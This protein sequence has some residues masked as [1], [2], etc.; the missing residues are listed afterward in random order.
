MLVMKYIFPLGQWLIA[1][2][3]FGVHFAGL[4]RVFNHLPDPE[5]RQH[6]STGYW[7]R[8][9]VL[10]SNGH[11]VQY[12][13]VQPLSLVCCTRKVCDLHKLY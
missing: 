3:D 7:S 12:S 5:T 13:T 8:A 4:P 6:P 2:P 1:F 10:D 9:E 11:A